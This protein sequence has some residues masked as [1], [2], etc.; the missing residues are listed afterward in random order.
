MIA[1][2][3]TIAAI[4][5]KSRRLLVGA[6]CFS[7]YVTPKDIQ[8]IILVNAHPAEFHI[9]HLDLYQVQFQE[10]ALLAFQTPVVHLLKSPSRP[11]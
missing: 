6:L 5:I 10:E 9:L 1:L 7:Y 4:V 11:I 2:V 8:L 3:I